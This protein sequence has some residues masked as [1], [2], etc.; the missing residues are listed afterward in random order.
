MKPPET[1][2]IN[3]SIGPLFKGMI[4][5][6]YPILPHIQNISKQSNSP[7]S[8]QSKSYTK[9]KNTIKIT[10]HITPPNLRASQ[11]SVLDQKYA[12]S[13]PKQPPTSDEF[14]SSSTPVL[15]QNRPIVDRNEQIIYTKMAIFGQV[16]TTLDK[17]FGQVVTPVLDKFWTTFDNR[18]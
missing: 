15:V 18:T 9:Y 11:I 12:C 7:H 3:K 13:C 17:Y 16:W 6:L 10:L 8:T 14:R 5:G 4:D 2:E 1:P